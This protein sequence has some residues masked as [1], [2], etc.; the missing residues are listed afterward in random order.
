MSATNKRLRAERAAALLAERERQE[1]RRRTLT[2]L[3]IVLGLVLVV[4]AGFL[5]NR[6]RDTSNDVSTVADASYAVSIGPE[7]APH[8]IVVYEDF[9][10]PY[11]GEL[12]RATHEEL[13]ALAD[14]GKVRVTYRPFVLLGNISDYSERTAAAFGVVLDASGSEVAKE[15]H[16]LLFANQPSEAGPYLDDDELVALAVEAGADEDEVGDAIRDLDGQDFAEAAT[17]EAE[18]AGVRS[19]PT[20]LVDGQVFN[21]GRTMDELAENLVAAVQ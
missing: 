17:A 5:V 11:C 12:E 1:K 4:A 8:E 20:I 10:C 16:D 14:E 2:V 21:D 19:T 6:L 18:D 15:F 9:L 3:G 13:A 7:D